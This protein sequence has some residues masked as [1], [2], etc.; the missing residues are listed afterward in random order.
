MVAPI[1]RAHQR[2]PTPSA[3]QPALSSPLHALLRFGEC[4][5][6][7]AHARFRALGRGRIVAVQEDRADHEPGTDGELQRE[8]EVEQVD[9]GDARDDDRERGGEPLQDVVRVLDDDGHDQAADRLQ[10]HQVHHERVVAE[11]EAAGGQLGAVVHRTGQQPERQRQ[12]AELDVAH[13]DGDVRALEHLLE[14]DAGQAGQEAGAERGTEPEQPVL[15][16]AVAR[17]HRLLAGRGRPTVLARLRQLDARDADDEQDEGGP[18]GRQQAAAQYQH[19]EHGRRENLQLVGDLVRGGIEMGRGHVQQIVLD[20]VQHR[21]DADLERV[22]RLLHDRLVQGGP[23]P[24]EVLALLEVHQHQ[25]GGEL[26]Q[27]RHHDRGR[28]E[29]QVA[30]ARPPVPHAQPEDGIL[31]PHPTSDTLLS[32]HAFWRPNA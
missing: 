20:D 25:A 14:V 1:A 16:R 5:G 29:E 19:R 18:L 23:Q 13:P 21:R 26:H 22:E 9:R 32:E 8:A 2:A 24:A 4:F 12:Q 27:L 10:H 15:L 30:R 6:G 28:A 17:R 7:R 31:Q 3:T 11:E